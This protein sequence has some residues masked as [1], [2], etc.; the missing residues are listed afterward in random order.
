M[1]TWRSGGLWASGERAALKPGGGTLDQRV[2]PSSRDA[3]S[4]CR[5]DQHLRVTKRK[6]SRRW[7]HSPSP[8][9]QQR[10]ARKILFTHTLHG[11]AGF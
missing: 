5:R 8:G 3:A 6:C 2:M 11:W 1:E 4:P 10:A 7:L 9:P